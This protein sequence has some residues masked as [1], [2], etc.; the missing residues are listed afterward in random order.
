MGSDAIIKVTRTEVRPNMCAFLSRDAY[1]TGYQAAEI[2]GI[3]EGDTVVVFG[4]GPLGV[5]NM[6]FIKE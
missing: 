1:P 3:K 5:A 4:A 2:A 6:F